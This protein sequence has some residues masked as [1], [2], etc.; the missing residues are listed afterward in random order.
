MASA[1]PEKGEFGIVIEGVSY[2]LVTTFNGLID[3][4]NHFAKDGS[5]PSIE[6]ILLR[7]QRGELEAVRAVFWSTLRRHHP[8][9]TVEQAGDLIQAAG[10]AGAV[11]AMLANAGAASAPDPRDVEAVGGVPNPPKVARKRRGIGARLN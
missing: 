7:A 1:N 2:V 4:Q 10:G 3:L 5:M 11:D 6:S 9:L 8:Q